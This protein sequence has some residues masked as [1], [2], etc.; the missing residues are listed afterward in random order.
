MKDYVI[1]R[2]GQAAFFAILE[3]A[4]MAEKEK[5]DITYWGGCRP[6]TYNLPG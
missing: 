1:S 2:E 5:N 4:A 3:M 6:K